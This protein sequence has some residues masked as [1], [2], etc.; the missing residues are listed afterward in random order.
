MDWSNYIDLDTALNRVR[1]N[2]TIYRKM[3]GLFTG[4][5]EFA[6]LDDAV[7]A[8]DYQRVAEAAHGIKGMTANLGFDALADSAT[9]VMQQAREGG[10]D[11]AALANYRQALAGTTEAVAALLAEWDQG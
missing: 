7:S 6:A 2:K 8:G 9:I 5:T 3:L 10:V 1:G 4:S 11:G